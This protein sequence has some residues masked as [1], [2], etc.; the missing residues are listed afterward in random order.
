[1]TCRKSLKNYQVHLTTANGDLAKNFCGYRDWCI[2]VRYL[3]SY[4]CVQ[5]DFDIR[6]CS[7][8]LTVTRRMSLVEQ[9]RLILPEHLNSPSVLSGVSCFSIFSFLCS[10]SKM[11]VGPF[12]F[13][14]FAILLSVLR[15]MASDW[16]S[17][18]V[19]FNA[20]SA[21]FQLY[22]GENKLIFSEMMMRSALY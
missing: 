16:V 14:L 3:F 22:H 2:F 17:E 9:E 8:H 19:L 12:V 18:W 21:V 20:N 11:I 10:V 4:T 13:F 15:F 6:W 7:C 5:H 1:M